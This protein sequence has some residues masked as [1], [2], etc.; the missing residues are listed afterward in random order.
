M[1]QQHRFNILPCNSRRAP[2]VEWQHSL[3]SRVAAI[4]PYVNRLMRF[5]KG[6][7]NKLGAVDESELDIEIAVREALANAVIHGNHE[8]PYKRIYVTCRCQMDGE[9]SITVRDEGEGFDGPAVP[10][11]THPQ[12]RLLSNGRG[13]Y[14]MRALMDEVSFEEP[15]N[16]VHMRKKLRMAFQEEAIRANCPR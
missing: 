3:S 1:D 10:D 5:I 11:P 7:M 6:F 15:G 16:T 13:I 8:D 2:F 4:S 12:R 9:V 14:L